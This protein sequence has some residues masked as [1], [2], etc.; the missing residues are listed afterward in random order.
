MS[1]EVRLFWAE[2]ELCD[3]QVLST[4]ADWSICEKVGKESLSQRAVMRTS[5]DK[6]RGAWQRPRDKRGSQEMQIP[7]SLNVTQG[8]F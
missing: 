8:E 4:W 1:F 5:L 6:A 2:T 3:L 7:F